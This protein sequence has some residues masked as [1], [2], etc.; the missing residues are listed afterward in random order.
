MSLFPGA[1]YVCTRYVPG[2]NPMRDSRPRKHHQGAES[3]CTYRF[4]AGEWSN[5]HDEHLRGEEGCKVVYAIHTLAQTR[6]WRK[7]TKTPKNYKNPKKL[8]KSKTWKNF[9]K[10]AFCPVNYGVNHKK[11]QNKTQKKCEKF[12]A[13]NAF[14]PRN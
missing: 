11:C 12:F 13:K 5:V 1:V 9:Q 3:L 14:L 4:G 7:I 2:S 8:Q 10:N 6:V